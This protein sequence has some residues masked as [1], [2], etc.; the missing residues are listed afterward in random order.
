MYLNPP[1]S[2][3]QFKPD[4]EFENILFLLLLL[5]SSGCLEVS[6]K[7]KKRFQSGWDL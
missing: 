3:S 4:F 1:L 6:I 2:D 7:P 5:K